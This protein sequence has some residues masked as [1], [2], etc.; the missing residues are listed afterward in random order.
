[1]IGGSELLGG[2][3]VQGAGQQPDLSWASRAGGV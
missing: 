2:G 3:E 1:M